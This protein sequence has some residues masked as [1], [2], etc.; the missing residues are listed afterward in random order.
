MAAWI[1]G[2]SLVTPSP[3]APKSPTPTERPLSTAPRSWVS[4]ARRVV[5]ARPL[6]WTMGMMS[7]P[8]A[9]LAGGR[10]L[11]LV[12]DMGEGSSLADGGK[13]VRGGVG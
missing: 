10:A 1:A 7:A 9:V 13:A 5:A 3:T 11:I 12:S 8:T 4:V 2:A 6:P